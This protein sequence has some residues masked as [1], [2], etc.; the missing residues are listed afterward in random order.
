MAKETLGA[1]VAVPVKWIVGGVV[2]IVTI[3]LFAGAIST[4][5]GLVKERQG[6]QTQAS[7]VD[8]QYQRAFGLLPT[9]TSLAEQYMA[10]ESAVIQNVTALRSGLG[11]AQS[12]SLSD[13]EAFLN[14]INRFVL[15][16]QGRSEA[17]PEL[18]SVQ[19]FQDTMTETINTANKIS[20]EKVRY[21]EVAGAY[22]AH[23]QSCCLPMLAAR[24]F[25]FEKAELIGFSDR[26]AQTAYPTNSTPV[27]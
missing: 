11:P 20:A 8:V 10:K 23:I 1:L 17:Y 6:V 24:L 18:K 4:Y 15:L 12:G 5:N 27:A 26:P 3:G 2:A 9:L 14:D 16:V 19:L 25:G 13:K 21:N 7:Q 22:N